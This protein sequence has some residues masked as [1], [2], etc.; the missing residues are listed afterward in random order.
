[1]TAAVQWPK[2]QKRYS[3]AVSVLF[4]RNRKLLSSWI[5]QGLRNKFQELRGNEA[6]GSVVNGSEKQVVDAK[7]RL[8][9]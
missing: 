7:A 6:V 3:E 5:V 4:W 2:V 9:C 8:H 1:M